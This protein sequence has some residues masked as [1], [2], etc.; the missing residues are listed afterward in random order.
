MRRS[1]LSNRHKAFRVAGLTTVSVG[2]AAA[3]LAAGI[4]SAGADAFVKLPGGTAH[5][6]G[7]TL[8]R[9]G[10]SAQ[11]SPSMASNP[12]SR[13]AWVSGT[14]TVKA[15]NLKPSEAGPTNGAEGESELPGTNGTS[16]NGAAATLSTGYIVGCQVDIKGLS[17]GLS[18]TLS[19][20]PSASAS[21]TVP[22][23]AGQVIFVQLTKK[24]IEKP[25]TYTVGYDRAG[26]NLQNCGG[27]AQARAFSTIETTGKLHQKV[28]LYGKPFSIG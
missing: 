27:Y 13:T 10:E 1:G 25:G 8:T 14:V 16:T 9:S 19:A 18:G 22:I 28:N 15:P 24:D 23:S 21:L 3:A 11:I 26:L 20:S 5:G 12:A 6:E 7:L 2:A 17:G 4:G